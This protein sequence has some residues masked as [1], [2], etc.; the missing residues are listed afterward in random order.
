MKT[1]DLLQ[2]I[3]KFYNVMLYLVHKAMCC[4]TTHSLSDSRHWYYGLLYEF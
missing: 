2:M 3:D 4:E 1:T